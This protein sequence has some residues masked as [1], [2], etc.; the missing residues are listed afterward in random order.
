V[1]ALNN[2]RS[3]PGIFIL[4]LLIVLLLAASM[5]VLQYAELPFTTHAKNAHRNE[6]WNAA[7]IAE[8]FD[9]GKCTPNEYACP[10]ADFRV[11]YCE[12]SPG[13]SIGLKIGMTVERI[14]SGHAA[15]TGYWQSRC[16]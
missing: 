2:A 12:I 6:T 11:S 16:P 7:N 4:A 13:L 9:A 8:Y 1:T 5:F 3:A 14:I 10:A 15:R